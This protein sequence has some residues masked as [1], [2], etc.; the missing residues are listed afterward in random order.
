MRIPFT[1][2]HGAGNDFALTWAD[3][4][5][6]EGLPETARAV[7]DR[8]TGVGADGWL[9]VRATP[10]ARAD[11]EIRLFNAD[12]SE[13]ELSGNGTRCAAAFLLDVGVVN[14]KELRIATGAGVKDLRLI[15]RDGRRFTFEM[16]MGRPAYTAADLHLELPLDSGMQEVVALSVGNP[17]CVVF[18]EN[19]DLDWR[20]MGMEI[21]R[22]PHFPNRTNVS[23]V[24]RI[25]SHTLEV[26]F[27]ERGV[28]ETVSSG[29][30]STGAMAAAVL[31]GVAESPVRIVTP[32]GP[33]D[34]RWDG[35]IFLTG[36]AEI[37]AA[38]EFYADRI[39]G[40]AP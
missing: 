29:T 4:A 11:A 31:R 22:Y 26:R 10:G 23:F 28:G 27:F 16:N 9:L 7:C 20:R 38:G 14:G 5:P 3:D 33:I 6:P 36:P 17:Q 8:H 35:D 32:A 40:E 30:G 2:A 15:D 19:F 12:G 25:D 21:E 1:K 18:V 37:V 24:R 39:S 13:P 34:L